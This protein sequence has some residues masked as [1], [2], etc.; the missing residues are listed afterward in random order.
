M[1]LEDFLHAD[2]SINADACLDYI[3][4]HD[5]ELFDHCARTYFDGF[6]Q[7]SKAYSEKVGVKIHDEWVL[8]ENWIHCDME[9]LLLTLV[10]DDE[11]D[12]M[13]KMLLKLN[14]TMLDLMEHY[15]VRNDQVEILYGIASMFD[16]HDIKEFVNDGHYWQKREDHEWCRKLEKLETKYGRTSYVMSHNTLNKLQHLID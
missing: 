1:K 9:L 16:Y 8:P 15:P 2:N 6:S 12:R 7:P 10:P 3:R 13:Y 4:K 5:E 14:P 11:I